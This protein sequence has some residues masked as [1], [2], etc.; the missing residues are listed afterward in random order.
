MLHSLAFGSN[1]I[2]K[3]ADGTTVVRLNSNSD[4]SAYKEE[5]EW[6]PD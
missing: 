2:I 4:K 6:F 5:G 1:C 3:I